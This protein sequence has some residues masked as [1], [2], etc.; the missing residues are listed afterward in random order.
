[1]VSWHPL[2]GMDNRYIL[3]SLETQRLHECKAIKGRSEPRP[4]DTIRH[5]LV[6]LGVFSLLY[7][8]VGVYKN[9]LLL[10]YPI[11][12]PAHGKLFPGDQILQMNDEPTEDISYERAIDILRYYI[13][14]VLY[15]LQNLPGSLRAQMGRQQE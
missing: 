2:E 9:Q 12:G 10:F 7:L 15:P 4:V 3:H 6:A 5:A 8:T 11:G 14:N 13:E 1:M